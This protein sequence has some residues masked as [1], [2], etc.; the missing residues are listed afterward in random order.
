MAV[1]QQPDTFSHAYLEANLSYSQLPVNG[2]GTS[3]ADASLAANDSSASLVDPLLDNDGAGQHE[4][5][6]DA[7]TVQ[8]KASNAQEQ[9]RKAGQKPT[10]SVAPIRIPRKSDT[11]QQQQMDGLRTPAS[12]LSSAALTSSFPMPPP[13]T[14]ASSSSP[15]GTF[16]SPALSAHGHSHQTDVSTVAVTRSSSP[17]D[18]VNRLSPVTRRNSILPR[19]LL[20]VPPPT[21]AFSNSRASTS[22]GLYWEG[23]TSSIRNSGSHP[24]PTATLPYYSADPAAYVHTPIE[25]E[26]HARIKSFAAEYSMLPPSGSVSPV[27]PSYPPRAY[28]PAGSSIL[29]GTSK[30]IAGSHRSLGN[31]S[32]GAQ[33]SRPLLHRSRSEHLEDVHTRNK[34]R[35][36]SGTFV[37]Y[38]HIIDVISQCTCLCILSWL[39]FLGNHLLESAICWSTSADQRFRER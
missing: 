14:P 28:S 26:P 37:G 9:T 17:L 20:S 16:G 1:A 34:R 7:E 35:E 29:S 8:Y 30:V 11:D 18:S 22:L 36:S 21:P 10:K 33:P 13:R 2:C 23:E 5:L 31:G 32:P 27:A 15:A 38:V 19:K 4:R 24:A 6:R 25:E 12:G 3:S 39:P